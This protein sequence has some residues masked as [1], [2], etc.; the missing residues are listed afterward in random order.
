LVTD[1]DSDYQRNEVLGNALK[2]L[3]Y[4]PIK[5]VINEG[6]KLTLKNKIKPYSND[7]TYYIIIEHENNQVKIQCTLS[8]LYFQGIIK[9]RKLETTAII[10][11]DSSEKALALA[12]RIAN[13]CLLVGYKRRR[14]SG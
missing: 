9:D 4:G 10:E 13:E 6:S 11:C 7:P 2:V 1:L 3:P 12:N 14:S 8:N 5:Q